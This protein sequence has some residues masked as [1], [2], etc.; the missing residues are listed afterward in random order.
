MRKGKLY[1]DP[2]LS[3]HKLSRHVGAPPNLVS[4]TLNEKIGSN[5]FDYVAHWR[6]EASR[7]LI[8]ACD[9]SV[10][11]IALDVGFN[12]RSTFYKAFK[13]ETGATPKGY[14]TTQGSQHADPNVS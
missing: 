8:L 11:A 13:R 9:A 10:L 5:F 1:L 7:P 3:L 6:I 14:R 4:Q 2:N 12:S